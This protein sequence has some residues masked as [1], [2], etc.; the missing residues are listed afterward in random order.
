[1]D[2]EFEQMLK[3]YNEKFRGR[4][5]NEEEDQRIAAIPAAC[6]TCV[7]GGDLKCFYYPGN[8]RWIDER[9]DVACG[10]YKKNTLHGMRQEIEGNNRG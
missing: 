5:I 2:A 10:K 1:M 7:Y 6:S 9:D 4:A 8:P 3:E